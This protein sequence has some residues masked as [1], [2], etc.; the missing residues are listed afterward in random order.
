MKIKFDVK[1]L[2]RSGSKREKREMRL[3]NGAVERFRD[4]RKR[5]ICF[6]AMNKDFMDFN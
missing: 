3:E 4:E 1:R 6:F 5:E 2:F